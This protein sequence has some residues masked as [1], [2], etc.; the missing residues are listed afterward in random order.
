MFEFNHRRHVESSAERGFQANIR[1][2]D[3]KDEAPFTNP[4]FLFD[5]NGIG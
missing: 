5:V 3:R 4:E 2:T 1:L